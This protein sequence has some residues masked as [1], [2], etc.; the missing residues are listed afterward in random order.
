MPYTT[1]LSNYYILT[2]QPMVSNGIGPQFRPR[3]GKLANNPLIPE[4]EVY[5]H[6]LLLIHLIDL[7]KYDKV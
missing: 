1:A 2:F 6:L 3:S 4:I 5:L 7:K